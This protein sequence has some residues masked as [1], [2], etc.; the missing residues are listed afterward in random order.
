M[1]EK[2][3]PEFIFGNADSEATM[4]DVFSSILKMKSKFSKYSDLP[5]YVKTINKDKID[6]LVIKQSRIFNH[7]ESSI[8]KFIST[9]HIKYLEL[10]NLKIFKPKAMENI[11]SQIKD[12]G[13]ETLILS[14]GNFEKESIDQFS[15]LLKNKHLNLKVLKLI[16]VNISS[17]N[18]IEIMKGLL[19]QEQLFCLD[20]S[21]N[22]LNED[23]L[24]KLED[25]VINSSSIRHVFISSCNLK[26]GH[27]KSFVSKV[28]KFADILE[29]L[30]ISGNVV[31]SNSVKEMIELLRSDSSVKICNFYCSM[32]EYDH[33]VVRD[34]NKILGL[35]RRKIA[36][37]NLCKRIEE[38]KTEN[39]EILKEMFPLENFSIAVLLLAYEK[40]LKDNPEL[41]PLRDKCKTILE[42]SKTASSGNNNSFE[43]ETILDFFLESNL[44]R[45][46]GIEKL[47]FSFFSFPDKVFANIDFDDNFRLMKI[48]IF[49]GNNLEEIPKKLFELKNVEQLILANNRIEHLPDEISK[50]CKLKVLDLRHNHIRKLN[51]NISK[52]KNLTDL[53]L[54]N[55]NISHIKGGIL[56]EL[57]NLTVLTLHS[58]FLDAM[59]P[60]LSESVESIRELTATRNLF[61]YLKQ[62][63]YELWGNRDTIAN[64]SNHSIEHM[65]YE[66]ALNKELTE[67][68]L[69]N[70]KLKYLPP[71]ISCLTKLKKLDLR[72][73]ELLELPP[74]LRYILPNLELYLHGNNNL[75]FPKEIPLEPHLP[76]KPTFIPTLSQFLENIEKLEYTRKT[77]N[78]FAIVDDQNDF[79][80]FTNNFL[81]RPPPPRQAEISV[82]PEY[83]IKRKVNKIS[84]SV[85]L[86][87]ESNNLKEDSPFKNENL[88][89]EVNKNF[90][91]QPKEIEESEKWYDDCVVGDVRFKITSF[92]NIH[93][94]SHYF[95]L[96]S[97]NSETIFVIISSLNN[98][99]TDILSKIQTIRCTNKKPIIILGNNA[100]QYNKNKRKTVESYCTMKFLKMYN[101]ICGVMFMTNERV[102]E[103]KNLILKLH[104]QLPKTTYNELQLEYLI[105]CEAKF[106]YPFTLIKNQEMNK[107]IKGCKFKEQLTDN[108]I[109]E[110]M[111]NNGSL[112]YFNKS[113]W[114]ENKIIFLEPRL[115]ISIIKH[116]LEF[117]RETNGLLNIYDCFCKFLIKNNFLIFS[118]VWMSVFI[119]FIKKIE[120]VFDF[121]L[122]DS[123]RSQFRRDLKFFDKEL[124]ERG[125][126]V[127]YEFPDPPCD[128]SVLKD[129]W[130]TFVPF[131]N[132]V[133]NPMGVENDQSCIF[134][135]RRQEQPQ[136]N[137]EQFFEKW[138][139]ITVYPEHI[140][141]KLIFQVMSCQRVK[142]LRLWKNLVVCRIETMAVFVIGVFTS[143]NE[144]F[145]RFGL[146]G[147]NASQFFFIL[148]DI[149]ETTLS[150][151][152][153][154]SRI[155]LSH[156]VIPLTDCDEDAVVKLSTFELAIFE[157]KH[158]INCPAC[159][160]NDIDHKLEPTRVAP[161]LS[162]NH[163][164]MFLLKFENL[165]E[166]K[167]IGRG[168]AGIIYRALLQESPNTSCVVAVKEL[169]LED[170]ED[171]EDFEKTSRLIESWR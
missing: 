65:P 57:K 54:H 36:R 68:D 66:I 126:L 101:N 23:F 44:K 51:Q 145:L 33:K 17:L 30:D 143:E 18:A 125:Y 60:D 110:N 3:E 26:E 15:S 85:H 35:N 49:T 138:F 124:Q 133:N 88:I 132:P 99:I 47:D 12:S 160:E 119:H 67:L 167:E 8:F 136:S 96:F 69:S 81:S 77:V 83:E 16:N 107:L 34:M 37:K 152:L 127:T 82:T 115:L 73:N 91:S 156:A 50:L 130:D 41:K 1:I 90:T 4:K 131:Q 164:S 106:N 94:F 64:F 84:Q 86:S 128:W 147:K 20:F 118:N 155:A 157:K 104:S 75:K 32:K 10:V 56:G 111:H 48:I 11:F 163:L 105:E 135:N 80:N 98:N 139:H 62:M 38:G 39:V 89:N 58:N 74:Q 52:L 19:N 117:S 43:G 59:P 102:K 116:I 28:F 170:E 169:N 162:L 46:R 25:F 70:N 61:H 2:L 148:N 22:K 103:F 151:T 108:L 112:V 113:T 165:L 134:N 144:T 122:N 24:K 5:N 45:E 171:T 161:Y 141:N 150:M 6:E 13:L 78:V 140:F 149:F 154:G 79:K 29:T 71:H 109:I 42:N 92:D 121:P 120:L 97:E 146:K 114:G 21:R 166:R 129:L 142:P 7:L 168:S 93:I 87:Q 153:K 159:S 14:G 9:Q 72:N 53:F 55:N 95:Y 100:Q 31:T 76:I 27:I 137:E 40:M 158:Q 63:C 123:I